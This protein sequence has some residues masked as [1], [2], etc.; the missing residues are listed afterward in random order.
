[1]DANWESIDFWRSLIRAFH[2]WSSVSPAGGRPTRP[3]TPPLSAS[4]DAPQSRVANAQHPATEG[5][6]RGTAGLRRVC[7]DRRHLP[8]PLPSI[9]GVRHKSA[10]YHPKTQ[11]AMEQGLLAVAHNDNNDNDNKAWL[12][13][14]VTLS[15]PNNSLTPPNPTLRSSSPQGGSKIGR[16]GGGGRGGGRP[17]G[18]CTPGSARRRRRGPCRPSPLTPTPPPAP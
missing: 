4:D 6:G 10:S 3:L 2:F 8:S 18:R 9:H 11:G 5:G 7:A 16:V 12:R 13:N 14:A 15:R 17:P 1:M